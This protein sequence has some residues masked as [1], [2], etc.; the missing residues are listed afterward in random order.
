MTDKLRELAAE[1]LREAI[2][3]IRLG[4]SDDALDI[5]ESALREA[6]HIG[7]ERAA[8]RCDEYAQEMWRA[9]KTGNGP[10]RASEHTQGQSDGAE[11][12]SRAIRAL[13]SAPGSKG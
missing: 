7:M 6:E 13:P 1:A 9:Y 8:A 5:I 10:Q 3:C 2:Q 4:K 11:N 12:C